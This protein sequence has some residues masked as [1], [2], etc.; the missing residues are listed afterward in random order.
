MSRLVLPLLC[1][2]LGLSLAPCAEVSPPVEKEVVQPESQ[3]G[4]LGVGVVR[5]DPLLAK[6]ANLPKGVGLQVMEIAPDS[7]AQKADLKDGDILHKLDD[8]ILINEDQFRQLIRMKPNAEVNMQIVRTGTVLNMKIKLGQ[9]AEMPRRKVPSTLLTPGQDDPMNDLLR[10][11][12][13]P[14]G[15]FG[16]DHQELIEEMLRRM[17]DNGGGLTP[18]IHRQQS[19]Q[20]IQRSSDGTYTVEIT[21]KDGRK[22]LKVTDDQ[23][24]VLYNGSSDDAKAIEALPEGARKLVDSMTKPVPSPKVVPRAPKKDSVL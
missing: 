3:N 17:Q 13:D 23:E 24:K 4:W 12:R 19:V 10:Q 2:L 21:E 20:S 9:R 22:T 7:P 5:L 18:Q 11:M 8:Q 1:G 14:N 16:R 6:G 15:P